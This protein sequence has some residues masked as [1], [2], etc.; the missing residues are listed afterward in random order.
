MRFLESFSWPILSLIFLLVVTQHSF[1]LGFKNPQVLSLLNQPLKFNVEITDQNI[2]PSS[3]IY[4]LAGT[5]D[6]SEFGGQYAIEVASE[7]MTK[8]DG[9]K[10]VSV[11]LNAGDAFPSIE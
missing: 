6:R 2:D 7:I 9:R 8:P 5:I 11:K 3:K 4:E 10:V 1:A